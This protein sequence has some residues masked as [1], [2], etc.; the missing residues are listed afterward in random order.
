MLSEGIAPLA[1]MGQ[2]ACAQGQETRECALISRSPIPPRW[3]RV[4]ER[5]ARAARAGEV[6]LDAGI[7][8][9]IVLE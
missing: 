8:H 3:R 6:H 4:V 1:R 9:N 2:S 7:A 5:V